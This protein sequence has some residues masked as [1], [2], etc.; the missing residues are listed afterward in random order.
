[1]A[2]GSRLCKSVRQRSAGRRCPD[3][4]GGTPV[5]AIAG[6][7]RTIVAGYDFSHTGHAALRRAVTLASEEDAVLHVV[8]V[9]DPHVPL[10][11]IPSKDGVDY[12][13]A[14]RVQDALGPVVADE[15]L[16]A[17]PAQ[18]V[19]FFVHTRI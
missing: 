15:A 3:R 5:A 8:C 19:S 14:A 7:Q 1:M 13:Y 12:R 17:R 16:T 10:P 6:M 18:P 2:D 4:G 9:L 11:S